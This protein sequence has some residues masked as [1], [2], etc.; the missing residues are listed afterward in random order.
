[1]ADRSRRSHR[2]SLGTVLVCGAG[3]AGSS[4]ARALLQVGDAVLLSDRVESAAV[5][6]LV[7]RGVRFVG[8]ADTLPAGVDLVVTSPGWRPDHPLFLDA[9][10]RGVEVIGEL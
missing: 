3:V 10:A 9:A 5:L 1:M 8:A 6:D 4:A 7:E 2:P